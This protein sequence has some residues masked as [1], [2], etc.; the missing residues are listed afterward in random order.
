MKKI[1]LA[2]V[3]IAMLSTSLMAVAEDEGIS[4]KVSRTAIKILAGPSSVGSSSST[5]V[6]FSADFAHYYV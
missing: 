2:T 1:V 6:Q 4:T 5:L 3:A